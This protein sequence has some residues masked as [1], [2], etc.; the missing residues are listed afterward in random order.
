[1]KVGEPL[2]VLQHYIQTEVYPCKAARLVLDFD[3]CV[4]TLGFDEAAILRF[5]VVPPNQRTLLQGEFLVSI[6][7]CRFLKNQDTV[8]GLGQSFM[9]KVVPG[10]TAEAAKNRICEFRFADD[11]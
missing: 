6:L 1:M 4:R 2:I 11:K 9:F 7:V 10:E 3:G 8:V 5:N